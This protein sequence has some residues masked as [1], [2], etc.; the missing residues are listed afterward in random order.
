MGRTPTKNDRR[1]RK[2]RESYARR[3][4]INKGNEEIETNRT[5]VDRKQQKRYVFCLKN[6][7][8]EPKPTL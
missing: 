8:S 2:R 6:Q 5:K 7:S 4:K 3:K 1:N